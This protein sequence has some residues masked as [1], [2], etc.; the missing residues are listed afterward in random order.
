MEMARAVQQAL[1]N[2][3]RPQL[4]GAK[5]AA[6]CKAAEHI[7][8]DFFTISSANSQ[9]LSGTA[10]RPGIIEYNA[11][12]HPSISVGI[13]DV[14]GHGI[15]SALVMALAT[16]LLNELS[17]TKFNPAEILAE[18]NQDLC[19]YLKGSTV[20]Y[21]TAIMGI[22][23]PSEQRLVVARAGHP[24]PIRVPSN[25]PAELLESDGIFLGM[26][27]NESFTETSYATAPGDRLIL[28]T[29]GITECKN[30]QMEEFGLER[31]LQFATHNR[32]LSPDDFVTALFNEVEIFTHQKSPLD[33]QT[34]VVM[35]L[36]NNA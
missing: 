32:A 23:Y 5:V 11:T 15:S 33:D 3:P 24:Y 35:D 30:K 13:G 2:R 16:G 28:F 12:D 36:E 22:Y 4:S 29:D 26:F 25:G 7:G 14:A 9:R 6:T 8:G 19:R 31:L 18:L 27:E 10:Q 17:R 34:V 20:S 1:L 21:V